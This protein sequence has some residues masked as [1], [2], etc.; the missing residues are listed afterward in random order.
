MILK[1][2]YEEKVVLFMATRLSH[3]WVDR[4]VHLSGT[5]LITWLPTRLLYALFDQLDCSVAVQGSAPKQ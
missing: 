5:R 1:Q 4:F 3:T 2:C